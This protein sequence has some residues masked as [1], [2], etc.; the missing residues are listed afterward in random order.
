M[1]GARWE[2]HHGAKQEQSE[3]PFRPAE[4]S[5]AAVF[6]WKT[7]SFECEELAGAQGEVLAG[8]FELQRSEGERSARGD[9]AA[10]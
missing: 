10:S 9:V 2:G 6:D 4:A 3:R 7:P 5:L 1:R 8:G